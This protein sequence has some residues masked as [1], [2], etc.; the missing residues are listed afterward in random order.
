A[1]VIQEDADAEGTNLHVREG[2]QSARHVRKGGLDFREGAVGLEAGR[3]LTSRDIGL[4]AAM[5]VPWLSVRQRPRV[6]LLATGDEIVLPG[7]PVGPGQIVSSSGPALA[8]FVLSCGGVPL[9]LGVA[10]DTIE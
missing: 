6:A 9:N 5:N 10:A 4:A 1:V 7:D 3:V 8:A 2:V